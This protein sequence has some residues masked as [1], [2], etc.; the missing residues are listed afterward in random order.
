MSAITAVD[1][2]PPTTDL[3]PVIQAL[4]DN[5]TTPLAE[6]TARTLVLCFDGTGD[7]FDADVSIPY[8][9]NLELQT[10]LACIVELE[11]YPVLPAVG[12]G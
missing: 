8:C 5:Q 12:K 3:P 1:N 2:S 7:Q 6:S 4:K 11:H 10:Q 9:Y